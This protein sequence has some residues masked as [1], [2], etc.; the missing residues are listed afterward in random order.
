MYLYLFFIYAYIYICVCVYIYIYIHTRMGCVITI[1][2]VIAQTPGPF[3]LML[4][5]VWGS[6]EM[7]YYSICNF[8]KL[9]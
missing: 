4:A 7:L 6:A 8:V 5:L 3:F 2:Y 1:L 9:A